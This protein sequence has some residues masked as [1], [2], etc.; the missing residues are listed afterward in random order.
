MVLV[1]GPV[2][3]VVVLEG[4]AHEQVAEDLAE[5]GV[6]GLVVESEGAGV[7]QVDGEFVGEA[8]AKNFSR[9]GHLLLHNTVVFLLLG[10]SFQSLPGK[11]ATAEVEHHVS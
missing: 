1:D 6:V 5:V 2:K 11:R 4:L 9:S 7:V 8:T 10:S 3:D